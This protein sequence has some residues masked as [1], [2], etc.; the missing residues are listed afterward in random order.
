MAYFFQGRT[1]SHSAAKN[2]VVWTPDLFAF[3]FR[4]LGLQMH[5][6]APGLYG[7]E[8]CIQA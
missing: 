6:G 8:G 4:G 5:G 3:A 2:Y 7:A 1:Q